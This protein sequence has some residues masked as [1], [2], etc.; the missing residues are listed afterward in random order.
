MITD[1]GPE[2]SWKAEL[3]LGFARDGQR[4]VLA[5]MDFSGPLRVQRPFY[6]EGAPCHC[7]VLHP[8]GGLVSGDRLRIQTRVQPG[9]HALLTTPSAG[10]VY[11][12]DSL[13]VTQGQD[14]TLCAQ[15]GVIEWLPMET[16]IFNRAHALMRLD[17]EL[18][19]TATAM[20]W[21]IV[22]LGR[23]AGN[24]P[25]TTGRLDQRLHIRRNN[26]PLLLENLDLA[27]GSPLQHDAFGL[28]GHTVTGTMFAAS[29]SADM[30]GL[31]TPLRES[32]QPRCGRIGVT[33][34]RGVLLVRYLGDRADEA[35]SLFETAWRIIRPA[36]LG[37]EACTPRI[38]AT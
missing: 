6:P 33:S 31:V 8:P 14:V 19:G 11:G 28:G 20:G 13:G 29:D 21:D 18:T 23:E 7:Y 4:T 1:L 30:P 9:A 26:R 24:H 27:G 15:D 38:W 35:R 16:I 10:K 32:L 25:F 5:D 17:V 22:C 36:L 37:L 12:T 3:R 2:R 34:R